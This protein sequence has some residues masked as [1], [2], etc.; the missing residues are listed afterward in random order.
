MLRIILMHAVNLNDL[1]TYN[2]T[3]CSVYCITYILFIKH[4]HIFLCIKTKN[5]NKRKNEYYNYQIS[6]IE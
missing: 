4:F 3:M 6:K 1:G 5:K 2:N